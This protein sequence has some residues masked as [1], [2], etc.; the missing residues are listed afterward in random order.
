MARG[1][2]G[3]G[4]HQEGPV[5]QGHARLT[6]RDAYTPLIPL[7]HRLAGFRLWPL[8]ESSWAIWSS[9]FSR[10][11]RR[12]HNPR[13]L[14]SRATSTP[15]GLRPTTGLS[16]I[17]TR[18]IEALHSESCTRPCLP[19]PRLGNHETSILRFV[20]TSSPFSFCSGVYS[21]I[22][23]QRHFGLCYS[24]LNI[25]LWRTLSSTLRYVPTCATRSYNTH[26]SV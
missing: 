13:P 3:V 21:S 25:Q 24:C 10:L 6:V 7:S 4:H 20:P 9:C 18:K 17:L 26:K 19:L 22:R 2:S 15:L 16:T 14:R 12:F 8:S 1:R 23:L 11:S 5:D